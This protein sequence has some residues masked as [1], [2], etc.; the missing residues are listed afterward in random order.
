MTA[1]ELT[2]LK[3][4]FRKNIK[5]I[6]GGPTGLAGGT[7]GVGLLA[8]LDA[9]ADAIG[10]GGGAGGEFE[11]TPTESLGGIVAGTDYNLTPEGYLRELLL[12][13]QAPAI[14]AFTINNLGSRTVLVGT[15]FA[16]GFKSFAWATTNGAN[17]KPNSLTIRDVTANTILGA[18]EPN[19]GAASFSTAA[20]TAVLGQS[21]VYLISGVNSNGDTFFTTLT[22]SGLFESFFGYVDQNGVLDMATLSSIGG[23][24]LQSG[25]ARTVGGVT[26]G[27][28]LYTVYA[29]PSTGSDDIAQVLQDGV[30]SIRGAFGPVRYATGPNSLG[31]SNTVGYIISNA[32]RAFTN[33]SLSFI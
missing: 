14:S 29:W 25:K 21:R 18:N 26:A 1:A 4:S 28:G 22:I 10:K 32:P 15:A 19:D 9:L 24:Q 6:A 20:F 2:A 33:S 5:V 11:L 27:P 8:A 3:A 16:G 13:Y 30:D 23:A 12:K 17:V 7:R 31:A